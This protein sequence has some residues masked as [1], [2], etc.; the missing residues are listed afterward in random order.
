[1]AMRLAPVLL[2]LAAMSLAAPAAA[3]AT[4][5]PLGGTAVAERVGD[6]TQI[7]ALGLDGGPATALTAPGEHASRPK[8]TSDGAQVVYQVATA[9]GSEIWTM[10][11]DGTGKTQVTR[12]GGYAVDPAIAPDH[13]HVVFA[14]GAHAG[15]APQL[16]SIP[17]GGGRVSRLTWGGRASSEPD[18]SPDGQ[19]IAYTAWPSNA[20][21][22]LS[23]IFVMAPDGRDKRKVS[24]QPARRA[25]FSPDGRKIAFEAVDAFYQAGWS[26]TVWYPASH[27]GTVGVDGHDLWR[28]T[29]RDGKTWHAEPIWAPDSTRLLVRYELAGYSQTLVLM[30]PGGTSEDGLGA[31]VQLSPDV[32]ESYGSADWAP[33]PL[34]R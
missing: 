25:D 20:A 14:Y 16:Y 2:T 27:V 34:V 18:F 33:G 6:G 32:V 17:T 24:I 10:Q 22:G 28:E 1:M 19:T 7:V 13:R 26:P 3:L 8:L 23:R 15:D 12:L 31:F 4:A 29:Y 30:T 5:V 21:Q 9:G 11:S